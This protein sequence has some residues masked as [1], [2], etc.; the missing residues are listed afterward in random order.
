MRHALPIF[1][2]LDYDT[3]VKLAKMLDDVNSIPPFLWAEWPAPEKCKQQGCYLSKGHDG[4]H[5]A[6]ARVFDIGI[7]YDREMRKA[8]SRSRG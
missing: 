8:P 5:R 7:D 6:V 2:C 3:Q 4:L 1:W